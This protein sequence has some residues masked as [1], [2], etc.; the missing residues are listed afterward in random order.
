MIV[1][2]LKFLLKGLQ[3]RLIPLLD[4]SSAE[5]RETIS[6]NLRENKITTCSILLQNGDLISLLHPL[7]SQSAHQLTIRHGKPRR[8]LI[9]LYD[10]SVNG[11]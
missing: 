3:I 9:T 10:W 7:F 11:H 4:K 8:N 2:I 1:T 6:E 5:L